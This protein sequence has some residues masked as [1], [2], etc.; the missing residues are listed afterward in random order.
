M[1]RAQIEEFTIPIPSL[2]PP[3]SL[4][5]QR[6]FRAFRQK[7]KKNPTGSFTTVSTSIHKYLIFSR[8]IRA[9]IAKIPP[10]VPKTSH[11][12]NFFTQRSFHTY[13]GRKDP[14][15]V[16]VHQRDSRNKR[17]DVCDRFVTSDR[18]AV[19]PQ[20]TSDFCSRRHPSYV[21]GPKGAIRF[22]FLLAKYKTSRPILFLAKYKTD[23][24]TDC[25]PK[26]ICTC[27]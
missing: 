11:R 13:I 8:K 2:S 9:T 20:K 18:S 14:P 24:P 26:N 6:Y 1:T 10:V 3:S 22:V 25:S 16:R 4:S 27:L 23:R 21:G 17:S 7:K 19:A 15:C 12:F 5:G